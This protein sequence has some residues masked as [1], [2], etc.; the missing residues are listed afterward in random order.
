MARVGWV[1]AETSS[2]AWRRLSVF[3]DGWV[4]LPGFARAMSDVRRNSRNVLRT[5]GV[6]V[7]AGVLTLLSS[8]LGGPTWLTAIGALV[9]VAALVRNAWQGTAASMRNATQLQ[10][11]AEERRREAAA[12][13]VVRMRPGAPRWRRA[14]S[15]AELHGWLEGGE[16]VAASDIVEVVVEP[17]DDTT[18]VRV[19]LTDGS[20]RTY[21][22][23][24]DALGRLLGTFVD[25]SA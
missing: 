24:D 3:D 23:P 8:A 17:G 21:T 9:V 13:H 2:G 16:L 19:L 7:L 22:S 12:G 6:A 4:E 18:R 25:H 15:A 10:Q 20:R 1:S 5:T 11:D 14:S